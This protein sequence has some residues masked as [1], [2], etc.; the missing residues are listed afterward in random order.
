M[1]APISWQNRWDLILKPA[2]PPVLVVPPMAYPLMAIYLEEG[3][4]I[5]TRHQMVM[6]MGS[7]HL[8]EHLEDAQA[9]IVAEADERLRRETLIGYIR[10]G[11]EAS[12]ASE[13]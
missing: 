11:A 10:Q 12:I 5:L 2:Y 6:M 7:R 3:L 9:I 4:G 1:T 13:P 8:A